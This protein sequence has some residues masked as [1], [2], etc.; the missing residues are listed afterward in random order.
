MRPDQLPLTYDSLCTNFLPIKKLIS[1]VSRQVILS[2][3]IRNIA[4]AYYFHLE[5]VEILPVKIGEQL[6]TGCNCHFELFDFD[7]G[8]FIIEVAELHWII[9]T[10][11]GPEA[12]IRR[13][14]KSRFIS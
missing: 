2:S 5:W 12:P 6:F 11:C 1:Y 10:F 4:C 14:L 7:Y 9:C 13:L 8:E 3:G